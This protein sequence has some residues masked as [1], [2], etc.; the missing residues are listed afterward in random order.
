MVRQLQVKIRLS[1]VGVRRVKLSKRKKEEKR[2]K[3]M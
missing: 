2:E 1:A 3:C